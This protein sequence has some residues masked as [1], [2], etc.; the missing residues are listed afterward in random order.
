MDID[1]AQEI[2]RLIQSSIETLRTI[3]DD[4]ARIGLD[5]AESLLLLAAHGNVRMALREV[6]AAIAIEEGKP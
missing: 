6:R 5:Y 3:A 1:K 4:A 2:E